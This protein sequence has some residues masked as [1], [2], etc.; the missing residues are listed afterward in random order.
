MASCRFR[1]LLALS[2][3]LVFLVG[4][5]IDVLAWGKAGH[6]VVATLAMDLLTPEARS[7]VADL[8]GSKVTLAEIANWADELRSTRPN[9]GPW[10]Y[11][12]IPRAANEYDAARDC[13]RGCIVSA[14]EESI[15]LLQD[16]S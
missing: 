13:P 9:T 10:H 8:L 16:T 1:T 12:N 4:I 7:R 5:P 15:R 6:R 11:V 3:T 2:L 14:I